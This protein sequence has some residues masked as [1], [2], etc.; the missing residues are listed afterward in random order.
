MKVL[1][2]IGLL[3]A[4][5]F[6]W[7]GWYSWF[8]QISLPPVRVWL[9]R[10]SG[11]K[12]GKDTVILEARYANLHHYG[13]RK[14]IIGDRCF[15]G[16]EVKL[17]VRGGVTMEDDVTLSGRVTIVTHINVGFDSH[18]LQKY[19]PTKEE[20][21]IIRRGAYIGTGAILLPGVTIGKESVVA[22]GAVV[23][24]DVPP[25]SVVVGVPAKC[26]KELG[27]S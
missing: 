17:D 22:A 9:L 3:K 1:Q 14:L 6:V 23:T 12:I 7:Y 15:V 19:Y 16:D 11:A 27:K 8:I 20:K 18:P 5:K 13:F 24:K 26:I 2:Q 25:R 4:F 10:C 21:V